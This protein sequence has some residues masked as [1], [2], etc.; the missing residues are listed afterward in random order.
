KALLWLER[1]QHR[2]GS[3]EP[4][5]ARV[6][7]V[8]GVRRQGEV[9]AVE[10]GEADVEDRLLGA[11]RR[12]DLALGIEAHVEA[13][14]VEVTYRASAVCTAAVARIAMRLRLAHG[15]LHRL[16][17]QPRRGPVRLADPP[18]AD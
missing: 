12:H 11:N 5:T 16:H 10:E 17:D 6:H 14:L 18:A 13:S 1:H 2:L 8:A 3:G 15:L 4:R 9:A 7:G